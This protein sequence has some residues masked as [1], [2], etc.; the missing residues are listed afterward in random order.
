MIST[1]R[2]KT[3]CI[4]RAR[5]GCVIETDAPTVPRWIFMIGYSNNDRRRQP[6]Y[7]LC[8]GSCWGKMMFRNFVNL[9]GLGEEAWGKELQTMDREF[10]FFTGVTVMSLKSCKL[11]S[12]GT[13]YWAEHEGS[14]CNYLVWWWA[15]S[16]HTHT[17]GRKH[18]PCPRCLY[19][20]S[21][22]SQWSMPYQSAIYF[23]I[24]NTSPTSRSGNPY[25]EMRY[26]S[27]IWREPKGGLGSA[28]DDVCVIPVKRWT[29]EPSSPSHKR[30]S[31]SRLKISWRIVE[32]RICTLA[33]V[34]GMFSQW[35]PD[36]A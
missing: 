2:Q 24:W 7:A 22:V 17:C 20:F 15:H 19:N 25:L 11:L 21:P 12:T 35:R 6:R 5:C 33:H 3:Y 18:V 34:S 27:Y 36:E 28:T 1:Q 4:G 32:V 10:E 26:I 9:I 29:F 30:A 14:A 8:A 13:A 23:Q 31:R 16:L